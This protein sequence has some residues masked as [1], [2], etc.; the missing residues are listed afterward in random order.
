[1]RPAEG[2]G[3]AVSSVV[4]LAERWRPHSLAAALCVGLAWSNA[5]RGAAP[6]VAAVGVAFAVA[7]VLAAPAARLPPLALG[8]PLAGWRG[9]GAGR[10]AG[11]RP[12]AA[13]PRTGWSR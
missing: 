7:C 9:G 1:D 13:G 8:L 5:V 10:A 11:G 4:A 12:G 3:G 2:A 6:L